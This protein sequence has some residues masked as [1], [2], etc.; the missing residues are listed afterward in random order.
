VHLR[1]LAL[2]LTELLLQVLLSPHYNCHLACDS[3]GKTLALAADCAL[4]FPLLC[5]LLPLL[6]AMLTAASCSLGE[7]P[8]HL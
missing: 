1:R 7:L 4:H 2:P 6:Q 3:S 5:K 8:P